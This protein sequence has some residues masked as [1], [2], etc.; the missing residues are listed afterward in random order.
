M[1]T[2]PLL[3]RI[4]PLLFV[5]I[6]AFALRF[7]D[8][9]QNPPGLY[10]DEISIAYNAHTIATKGVDEYGIS[11]PLTF[12]TYGEYKMPFYIYA[13]AVSESIFGK[14]EFAVRLPSAF[15]GTF[16]ILFLYLFL[17]EFTVLIKVQKEKLF[18]YFPLMSACILAISPW[19][20]HFSRGGFEAN[21]ALTMFVISLFL[22]CRYLNKKNIAYLVGSGLLF[23]LTLYTYF[24]YRILAPITI[25]AILILALKVKKI[26]WR[27]ILLFVIIFGLVSLPIIIFSFSPEGMTRFSQTS[28]FSEI[29]TN[30]TFQKI[31]LYPMEYLKNYLAYFSFPFWF[32]SG[33]GIGR[34]Q[35]PWY[36]PLLKWQ[37]PFL[38]IGLYMLLRSKKK[39]FTGGVVGLL[40][41]SPIAA[42]FAVPSP[43]TLRS[44]P[45]VIPLTI[46]T[47]IG[48]ITV[49][50]YRNI[51]IRGISILLVCIAGI[52][53]I[54]YLHFYYF[55]YPRV[56]G[57]DWG[58]AYKEVVQE[59]ATYTKMYDI[60]VIDSKLGQ[61]K[62]YF[63][64]YGDKTPMIV[65]DS[66]KKP[67]ALANKKVL[68]IRP[69]GITSDGKLIKK[70]FLPSS[71][72]NDVFA[73]F[74][75]I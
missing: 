57:L 36:G 48:L 16:A 44:L 38:L 7:Y 3:K 55:H 53:F 12:K 15:L 37:I 50:Q 69:A 40:L 61:A 62:T 64:Y 46:L 41:L 47:S 1:K 24:A 28:A 66:W 68:F 4:F 51:I 34:H 67:K 59:T 22:F 45:M 30:N 19:H 10:I 74:W 39:I 42:S 9:G 11:Y 18:T 56:N 58:G 60:I 72:N 8:L 73:E 43:H 71:V 32:V 33:D 23:S 20:I 25:L 63:Q 17:K 49:L 21:V 65:P 29:Q 6:L 13:A 26:A 27:Q 54:T 52:E 75:E 31:Y 35:M 5:L 14:N 70:V 2:L